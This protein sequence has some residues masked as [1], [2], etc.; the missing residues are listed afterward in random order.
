MPRIILFL[1]L[2]MAAILCL[3]ADI[4]GAQD[5]PMISRY[6]GSEIIKY[7]QRAFD[8]VKVI[9]GVVQQRGGWDKNA[10]SILALEGKST[11][12]AYRAP[13]GRSLFEVFKNYEQALAGAGFEIL[14]SCDDAN[15]DNKHKG[16]AFNELATPRDLSVSMGFHE[17][18]QRY[19]LARLQRD[20]QMVHV[21]LYMVQ[22]YSIGGVN[23]NR[24]FAN[25]QIVESARMQTG[26]VKV[27]AAAMAK[28]L[29]AE[30]HIA[31]YELYFDT[32]SAELKT[33]S[34]SALQEIRSLLQQQPSL[35]LLVVGHTD[36]QGQ[37]DY[38]RQLSERRAKAVV[39]ALVEKHGIA[40]K[41]LTPVGVGMAA[42]VA[43]N[44]GETGRAKNRRVEL[45][46][47]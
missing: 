34:D 20:D 5:H 19:L 8:Q 47:R 29:E 11:R 13:E 40:A 32:D 14:F 35:E 44:D 25:L 43:S 6:P 31:L 42:P 46:K 10:D 9:N 28:G 16:R 15:C 45:V 41:R 37:L 27:D 38:N 2:Q 26:L 39:K 1:W 17:K 33:E 3:A 22:A 30:G 36:N 21:A 4:P 12:I 7:D 18:G 23:K 24:I